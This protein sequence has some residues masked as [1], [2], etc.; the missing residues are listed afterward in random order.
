MAKK[1]QAVEEVVEVV[2]APEEAKVGTSEL[3]NALVTA[4]N[5]AKGPEKKT[6]FNRKVNTPWTPKDGSPKLK[7][8][9][10][11]YQHGLPVNAARVS[12]EVIKLLNELQPGTY[13]DGFVKV[14]K[15]RDW[16]INVDYPIKTA[17]QRLRLVNQFGIRNFAELLQYCI[18]EYRSKKQAATPELDES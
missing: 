3:A 16:G 17:A 11:M 6:P 1:A 10:K 2:E 14:N 13:C 15:R 5:A 7:L 12:N 4:I 9:R 8:T 18:N